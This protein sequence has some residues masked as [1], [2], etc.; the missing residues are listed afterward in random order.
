MDIDTSER[1]PKTE[2]IGDR[3]KRARENGLDF[4]RLTVTALCPNVIFI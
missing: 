3:I 1:L 4:G 2:T